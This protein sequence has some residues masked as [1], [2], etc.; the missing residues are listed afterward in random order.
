MKLRLILIAVLILTGCQKVE[1]GFSD[2]AS[3][4]FYVENSGASMRVLV[5]GN[6]S[7]GIFI[8]FVH[9]GPGTGAQVYDT[10]Y[11]K[12]NLEDKYAIAFWDQRNSGE[13][14]GNNNKNYLTLNQIIDD[15]KKIVLVIKSRYGQDI[16]LFLMS[17]SF[18]G[19]V[20]A[21]FLTSDNNQNLFK[22]YI[23][24][25]GSHNYPLNDTLTREMLL[26]TAIQEVNGNKHS[27]EWQEI[28]NYCNSHKGNF[29]FDQSMELEKYAS[30]AE[31]YIKEVRKINYFSLLADNII[32]GHYAL[33]SM[34][35][36]LIVSGNSEINKEIAKKEYSS[37]LYRIT[38]P[39]LLLYGKYDFICPARLGDDFYSRIS[40]TEKKIVISPSSGHNFIFQDEALF[41][42]EV[43]TFIENYR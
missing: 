33:T 38:I 29:S 2:H 22:G 21:G 19:L 14:Q 1:I 30:K 24:I 12:K 31:G 41:G 39:V 25:D 42:N 23:N 17:H 20:S 28:I 8:L 37:S 27:E 16:D 9:G 18:G 40:S 32:S 43:V 7:S 36:N 34:L 5:E 10:E 13:S 3:D 6:T 15:L 35:V 26:N 11:I 4:T